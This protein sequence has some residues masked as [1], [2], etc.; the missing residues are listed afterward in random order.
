MTF[1]ELKEQVIDLLRGDVAI[2]FT[3]DIWLNKLDA[4]FN[5]IGTKTT[6]R[7]WIL[8]DYDGVTSVTIYKYF[9]DYPVER[10]ALPLLDDDILNIE[11]DLSL[12]LVYYIAMNEAMDAQLTQKLSLLL[13]ETTNNYN[14][15]FYSAEEI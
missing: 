1:L 5:H 9:N 4:A 2:S 6:P 15:N 8:Y 7:S 14:W 12:A 3:N 11:M 13:S 10:W